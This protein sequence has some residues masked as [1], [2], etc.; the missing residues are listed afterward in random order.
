M[1]AQDLEHV[2]RQ[3]ELGA[4]S[5]PMSPA[6][7]ASKLGYDLFAVKGRKRSF[8]EWAVSVLRDDV[9]KEAIKLAFLVAGT[10]LLIYFGLSRR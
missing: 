10:A 9:V 6:A 5:E 7:V 8:A 1:L 4:P 3:A 2:G